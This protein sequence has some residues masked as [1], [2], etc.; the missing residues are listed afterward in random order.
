[1]MG[2]SSRGVSLARGWGVKNKND[3]PKK[4]IFIK[5]SKNGVRYGILPGPSL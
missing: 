5:L 4:N 2:P 1:M 3:I